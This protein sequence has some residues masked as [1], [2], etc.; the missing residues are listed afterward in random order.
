M[1]MKKLKEFISGVRWFFQDMQEVNR[2]KATGIIEYEAQQME[3]IFALMVC[4]SFIGMPS[5][6]VHITLQLLPIMEEEVVQL[7][8]S[9]TTA[10]DALGELSEIL[11]EP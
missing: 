3:N 7:F 5:P 1:Y 9:I 2:D 6:P 4:G 10:K 8:Q 11:G